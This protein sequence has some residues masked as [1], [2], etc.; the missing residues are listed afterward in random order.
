MWS[1]KFTANFYAGIISLGV[2]PEYVTHSLLPDMSMEKKTELLAAKKRF[3]D[4][5]SEFGTHWI[6]DMKMGSRYG[7]EQEM[8]TES[9]MKGAIEPPSL[10]SRP[11]GAL[12]PQI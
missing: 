1:Q 4:L 11:G 2:P 10:L 3:Y 8:S 7:M 12:R 9:F 5:F 6:P